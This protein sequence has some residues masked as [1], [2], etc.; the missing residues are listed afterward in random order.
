MVKHVTNEGDKYILNKIANT[1]IF[2][3]LLHPFYSQERISKRFY[4]ILLRF[5]HFAIEAPEIITSPANFL[6][7]SRCVEL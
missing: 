2:K 7:I 4:Y 3:K 1:S 6:I 5:L